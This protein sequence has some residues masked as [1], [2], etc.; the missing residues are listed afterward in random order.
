MRLPL[1][2]TSPEA[3]DDVFC[4]GVTVRDVLRDLCQRRSELRTRVWRDDGSLWVG[5]YLNGEEVRG[6]AGLA[7]SV[8]DG[9]EVR[10]MPALAGEPRPRRLVTVRR[11]E[12][13]AAD[14]SEPQRLRRRI[15]DLREASEVLVQAMSL[16][17]GTVGLGE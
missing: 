12:R 4:E 9:D 5:V 16:L 13:G 8:A 10:L 11:S 6:L 1:S 7:T 14:G 15:E 17:A 2:T 3:F